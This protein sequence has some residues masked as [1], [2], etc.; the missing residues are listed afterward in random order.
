MILEGKQCAS[1]GERQK[2][3]EYEKTRGGGWADEQV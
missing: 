1:E 3:K 2:G